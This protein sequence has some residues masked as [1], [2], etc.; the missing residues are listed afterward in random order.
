M[1]FRQG[2]GGDGIPGFVGATTLNGDQRVRIHIAQSIPAPGVRQVLDGVGQGQGYIRAVSNVR[3]RANIS[4]L[5]PAGRISRKVRRTDHQEV[6]DLRLKRGRTRDDDYITPLRRWVRTFHLRV[7]T[8]DPAIIQ[9]RIP[10]GIGGIG[11]RPAEPGIG[12]GILG[13]YSGRKLPAQMLLKLPRV[14]RRLIRQ[15][16]FAD[17]L[18]RQYKHF[19]HGAQHEYTNGECRKHLQQGVALAPNNLAKNA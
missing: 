1:Q 18:F 17:N 11:I 14:D 8:D 19:R 16:V 6:A 7:G 9:P 10:R 13:K 3:R 12:L 2:I 5:G 4:D 15:H